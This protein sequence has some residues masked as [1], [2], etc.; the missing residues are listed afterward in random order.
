[1]TTLIIVCVALIGLQIVTDKLISKQRKI[2]QV[3]KKPSE[4]QSSDQTHSKT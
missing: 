2:H 3:E 1:M 4:S